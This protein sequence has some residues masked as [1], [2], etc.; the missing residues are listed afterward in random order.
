MR[1]KPFFATTVDGLEKV[2]AHEIVIGRHPFWV[3]S[4]EGDIQQIL[5]TMEMV[6]DQ[7]SRMIAQLTSSREYLPIDAST[8]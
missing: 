1:R 6:S 4:A 5:T 3:V 7:C 2:G 8:R